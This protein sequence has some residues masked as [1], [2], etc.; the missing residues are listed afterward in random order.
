MIESLPR[1]HALPTAAPLWPL[2]VSLQTARWRHGC[3]FGSKSAQAYNTR[4][5]IALHHEP[6]G[7]VGCKGVGVK[8]VG[9]GCCHG[10]VGGG[11]RAAGARG[12][13]RFQSGRIHSSVV[14]LVGVVRSTTP[15]ERERESLA[16]QRH[17]VNA[18]AAQW[19]PVGGEC[20]RACRTTL[21]MRAPP[22]QGQPP[23]G[24]G[25]SSDCTLDKGKQ[26]LSSAHIHAT[27]S[28]WLGNS[29][30]LCWA[31]SYRHTFTGHDLT[32]TWT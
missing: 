23:R 15:T 3:R 10:G 32:V 2:Q 1:W 8:W 30:V 16:A 28:H 17:H 18:A 21:A 14:S 20:G 19:R 22:R 9:I 4:R 29:L 7:G 24:D 25:C 26:R 6:S 13:G 11:G 31:L 27:H 5:C 12:S